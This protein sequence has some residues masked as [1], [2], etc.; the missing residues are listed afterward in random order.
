MKMYFFILLFASCAG[1]IRQDLEE[2]INLS[3]QRDIVS[4]II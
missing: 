4:R 3:E 1:I 2:I